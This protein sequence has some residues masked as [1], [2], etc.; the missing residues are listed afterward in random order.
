M[1]SLIP[2]PLCGQQIS[3]EAPACP[4]C[5]QPMPKA[6]TTEE[7]LNEFAKGAAGLGCALV[8]LVIVLPPLLIAILSMF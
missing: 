4:G 7:K 6:K 2:C 1:A 8:L 5:G 3:T